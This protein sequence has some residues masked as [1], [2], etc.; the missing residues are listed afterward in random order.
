VRAVRYEALLADPHAELRRLTAALGVPP[1]R[2]LAEVV[3][4]NTL[5]ELRRQHRTVR[6]H[7]WRGQ[8]GTWRALL[9]PSVAEA[10][11]AAHRRCFDELGY[12]CDPDPALDAAQA[13]VNWYRFTWPRLVGDLQSTRN[14][15]AA[16]LVP[17]RSPT[18]DRSLFR[19]LRHLARQLGAG[20]RS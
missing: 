17:P 1:L 8:A 18:D 20:R 14:R 2:P 9:P 6:D 11:F 16:A 13:E 19:K 10:V 5:A 12:P 4:A 3:Q 7:F 15:L